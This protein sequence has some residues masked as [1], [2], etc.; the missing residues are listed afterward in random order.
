[1]SAGCPVCSESK[2]HV[3]YNFGQFDVMRCGGCATAWRSNMYTR[4]D[5]VEMY[6]EEPYEE[7]PFFSYDS[8]GEAIE[9]VPRFRRFA[10]ATEILEAETGVGRLLDVGCG[11]GT[12]M[13]IAKARGWEVEGVELSPALS[14]QARSFGRVTTAAFEDLPPP[15][16][17]YD[18][19]TMWDVIEHVLDPLA[20]IEKARS[21]VRPGGVVLAC[22]PDEDS[23]LARV[24]KGIYTGSRKH[25]SGPALALH[26][27]YHTFFFSRRS[28]SD[29]FARAGM[30]V[31]A[32]Y[33]QEAFVA[34]SDLATRGQKIVI[35]AI[36]R[37]ARLRDSCYECVVLARV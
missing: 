23:L 37:V 2:V 9:R 10:K 6:V 30:E 24:G 11:A 17:L 36:E 35:N 28:L 3:T 16:D 12:Y 7:H 13:S 29:L 22:T 19:L 20:W 14:K 5:I 4:D 1:M 18:A 26:P 21:F 32:G 8:N 27:R 25:V 31:V 33:S 15:H 34:H